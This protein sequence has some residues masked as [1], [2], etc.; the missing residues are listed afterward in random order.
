MTKSVEKTTR[1][2]PFKSEYKK[3]VEERERNREKR[4]PEIGSPIPEPKADFKNRDLNSEY[5]GGFDNVPV[6]KATP[7]K[8]RDEGVTRMQRRMRESLGDETP[9][10]TITKKAREPE[11]NKP[12]YIPG[13]E[14]AGKPNRIR[15]GGNAPSSTP[16]QLESRKK[17]LRRNT[18]FGR[19]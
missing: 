8:P 18:V 14:K 4:P 5:Y 6:R 10:I 11:K 3:Y 12:K 16:E 15:V 2:Q 17:M 9:T 1:L 13:F 19:K 7:V